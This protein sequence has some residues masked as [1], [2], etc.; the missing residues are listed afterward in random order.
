MY[1]LNAQILC[2]IMYIDLIVPYVEQQFGKPNNHHKHL[3][4]RRCQRQCYTK[5][6]HVALEVP[7]PVYASH[8]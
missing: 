2:L 8:V 1:G 6:S 3:I 5:S 4:Q 7:L